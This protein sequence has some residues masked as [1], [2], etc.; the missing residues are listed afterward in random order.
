[1]ENTIF[2]TPLLQGTALR[3][4]DLADTAFRHRRLMMISVAAIVV[5]PVIVALVLPNY[6]GEMKFLVVRERVDPVVTPSAEKQSVS[7]MNPPI[8]SEEELNSEVELLNSRDLLRRVVITS[9]LANLKGHQE[10]GPAP[11]AS[12][13]R[14]IEKAVREL[15]RNLD[16]TPVRKTNIIRVVYKNRDPQLAARVLSD[17]S[18][19]Y[20]EKH[21][22]VHRLPGQYKFFDQE[23]ERYRR[24]LALAEQRLADFPRKYGVV[25]PSLSRD[26]TLQKLNDFNASLQQT[27]A[28]IAE[29]EHRVGDLEQQASTTPDRITTQ[30]HRADNP[31]LL[32]IMK[33]TLLNLD[34]KRSELLAKYQPSY[35][36]VQEVEKE[37]ANT[38]AAIASE[39]SA[40]VKDE[41]SDIN[42]VR[43]WI[44]SELTKSRADLQGLRARAASTD[45]TIR[46]YQAKASEL[47]QRSIEQGDLL[48][49]AKEEESNYL[50]Y[51]SKRE[52]ARITE[53]L[54]QTHIL[55]VTVAEE[56][57]VPA[58]PAHAPAVYA[59]TTFFLMILMSVGLMLALHYLDTTL[60]SESDIEFFLHTRMLAGIPLSLPGAISDGYIDLRSKDDQSSPVC[61]SDNPG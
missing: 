53:S 20:L 5:V 12:E 23:A 10:I 1:M 38:R 28:A 54:D 26:I 8:V 56:P 58:L 7:L 40:P 19:L 42:P 61:D 60:R 49:T 31:Q 17:L 27:R 43:E 24:S 34:L 41:T 51:L 59:M 52:E 48:R 36:P 46:D 39:D 15:D 30:F 32:E 4:E 35:R 22:D 45:E 50:L 11:S 14:R 47:E 55:N 2:T 3:A 16:A 6:R 18:R 37:I 9:G 21:R 44:R 13:D 33:S 57:I 25:S 29:T